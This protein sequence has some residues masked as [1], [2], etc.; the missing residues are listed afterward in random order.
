M[1]N[2]TPFS[3]L[4]KIFGTQIQPIIDYG[5]EVWYQGKPITELENLYKNFI[6]KTLGLKR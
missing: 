2:Q 1:G 4:F 3:V 6:K 5:C